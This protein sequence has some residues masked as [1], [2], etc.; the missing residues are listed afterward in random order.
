MT[1]QDQNIIQ[2]KAL[3]DCDMI[4]EIIIKN[5]VYFTLCIENNLNLGE[6]TKKLIDCGCKYPEIIISMHQALENYPGKLNEIDQ[7]MLEK[8]DS[9]EI[10][11]E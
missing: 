5:E 4:D 1:L 2:I 7:L 8:L 6:A 3:Y 11:N 10:K 9:M